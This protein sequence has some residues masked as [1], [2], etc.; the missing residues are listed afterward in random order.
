MTMIWKEPL[1]TTNTEDIFIK[2]FRGTTWDEGY[3]RLGVAGVMDLESVLTGA[4]NPLVIFRY[5]P[6][7]NRVGVGTWRN[8]V[9]MILE[10]ES[11]LDF[12]IAVDGDGNPLVVDVN[13]GV[14]RTSPAWMGS[15]RPLPTT[16]GSLFSLAMT[17]DNR[18]V[19]AWLEGSTSQQ[20]L[21]VA[22]WNGSRWD[23]RPIF[24]VAVA[25]A[26]RPKV[27]VDGRGRVWVAWI[28]S[29]PMNL[30]LVNV[31]RSNYWEKGL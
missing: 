21:N 9:P 31:W 30:P 17:P 14:L 23:A 5:A 16:T 26:D 1:G 8:H 27:A 11:P 6:P 3:P 29:P 22:M 25:Y 15:S 10:T 20:K 12:T 24:D 28:Q 7:D 13:A 2:R 19:L 4:G 18:P